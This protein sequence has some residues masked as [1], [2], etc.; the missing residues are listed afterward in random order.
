ML[1]YQVVKECRRYTLSRMVTD[2]QT[3]GQT[4]CEL[5]Q[6]MPRL[7]RTSREQNTAPLCVLCSA[8]MFV[9]RLSYMQVDDQRLLRPT[10]T[11]HAALCAM[12]VDCPVKLDENKSPVQ[13]C[14]S[15]RHKRE[16]FCQ[17]CNTLSLKVT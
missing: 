1:G 12:F 10:C 16:T 15:T 5:R 7:C 2:R 14:R 3:G 6:Q 9:V 11:N 8:C 4:P 17:M 13:V